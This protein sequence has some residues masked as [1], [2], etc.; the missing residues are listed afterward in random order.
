MSL[1]SSRWPRGVL[2]YAAGER[3]A[4]EALVSAK[5][6]KRHMP[7]LP[8]AIVTDQPVP[9]A[10]F[11]LRLSLAPDVS[12]K[13]QKMHALQHSPFEQ[14]LYLDTDTYVADAI[15]EVF[16]L[17]ERYELAAALEPFSDVVSIK[18]TTGGWSVSTTSR[19]PRCTLPA[20][21]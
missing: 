19:T 7:D 5:S 4:K 20:S 12:I 16:D 8:T 9:E 1:A 18:E 21:T 11:D 15:W 6:V 2:Y 14:T 3:F 13:R 10:L 17:L